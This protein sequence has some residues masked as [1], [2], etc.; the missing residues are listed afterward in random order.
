VKWNQDEVESDSSAIP[1]DDS[2][3]YDFGKDEIIFPPGPSENVEAIQKEERDFFFEAIAILQKYNDLKLR[4]PAL[5]V[6]ASR[7]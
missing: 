2:D 3:E 4:Y 6:F 1:D 5:E 7:R